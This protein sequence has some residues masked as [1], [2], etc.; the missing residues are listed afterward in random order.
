[1]EKKWS[2]FVSITCALVM[3]TMLI[4]A[5]GN[6]QKKNENGE[7]VTTISVGDIPTADTDPEANQICMERIANFEKNNPDIKIKADSYVF[8]PDSYS[9]MAAAGTLPTTYHLPFT[10]AKTVIDNEYTEDVSEAF[11]KFGIYDQISDT[12]MEKISSDGKIYL[13]PEACYDSG[14][15]LNMKLYKQ[16]GLVND[17][18]MP[19]IPTTWEELAENAKAIKEKTGKTGFAMPAS[20]WRFMPIAWSFGG[21]FLEQQSDG[22]WK[23]V[24]DSPEVV[25][26]LEYVKDLKWKYNVIQENALINSDG[27]NQLLASGE[28]GMMFGEPI[29]VSSCTIFGMDFADVGMVQMPAGPAKHVTLIGGT[30][31]AVNKGA[32]EKE[33]EA[34]IR[35]LTETSTLGVTLTDTA[36]KNINSQIELDLSTKNVVGINTISPW[37]SDNAVQ[38]YREQISQEKA[39]VNLDYVKNYNDKSNIEFHE[40]E[41]VVASQLYRALNNCIQEVWTNENADCEAL[42]KQTAADFQKNQLDNLK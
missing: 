16:A 25:A 19:K 3:G 30:Y 17:D 20:G 21:E 1:M 37:K 11:K 35:W 36:K 22:K 31:S 7:D 14:L 12:I 40:E 34:V 18:G 32:T 4:S 38:Q 41:P 24:F 10:Q 8:S 15:V 33:I 39:N 13:I 28:A 29:Q 9:A 27:V 6:S 42:L 26:A 2:R 23:A 5:C